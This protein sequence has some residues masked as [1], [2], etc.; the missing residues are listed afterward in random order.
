[1]NL[2]NLQVVSRNARPQNSPPVAQ[3][4]LVSGS[5]V[6]MRDSDR[7]MGP[8]ARAL[9]LGVGGDTLMGIASLVEDQPG[10]RPM[11]LDLL[12]QVQCSRTLFIID[13]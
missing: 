2:A 12:W 5:L 3:R 8:D 11:A 1:V 4:F 7:Q 13:L 6:L 9:V 10:S